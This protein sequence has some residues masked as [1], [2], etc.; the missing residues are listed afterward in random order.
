MSS[1]GLLSS[2]AVA[3]WVEGSS[4]EPQSLLK[5]SST[6][7]GEE[8]GWEESAVSDAANGFGLER[9]VGLT[10]GWRPRVAVDDVELGLEVVDWGG[11]ELGRG[12][13]TGVE[14]PFVACIWPLAE[15]SVLVKEEIAHPAHEDESVWVVPMRGAVEVAAPGG[16]WTV[17]GNVW[18]YLRIRDVNMSNVLFA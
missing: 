11:T 16:G 12:A 18:L 8:E 7:G 3:V 13:T 10:G 17:S 2:A 9:V 6:E 4:Q 1:Q 5:D 15:V 14:A